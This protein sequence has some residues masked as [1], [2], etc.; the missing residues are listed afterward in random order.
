MYLVQADGLPQAMDAKVAASLLVACSS[1]VEFSMPEQIV[2]TRTVPRPPAAVKD[3]KKV[4]KLLEQAYSKQVSAV[5]GMFSIGKAKHA[6][7]EDPLYRTYKTAPPDLAPYLLHRSIILGRSIILNDTDI[8]SCLMTLQNASRFAIHRTVKI[9]IPCSHPFNVNLSAVALSDDRYQFSVKCLPFQEDIPDFWPLKEHPEFWTILATW[10]NSVL[11]PALGIGRD[12]ETSTV[13]TREGPRLKHESSERFRTHSAA[14]LHGT[15]YG[16]FALLVPDFA[17]ARKFFDAASATG[18]VQHEGLGV[19]FDEK[20]TYMTNQRMLVAHGQE[21]SSRALV[22]F[23]KSHDPF[24]RPKRIS[25]DHPLHWTVSSS[26]YGA[27][28]FLNI[29]HAKSESYLEFCSNLPAETV[30]SLWTAAGE[31]A[32]TWTDSPHKRWN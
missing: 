27:E 14:Q 15:P 32:E 2:I 8:E 19:E 24:S 30:D 21:W 5:E 28:S 10:C 29:V 31:S 18:E 4:V 25:A 17:Q 26:L 9:G 12:I 1:P 16:D 13:V 23:M 22:T 6:G 3:L 7:H 11:W 20:S